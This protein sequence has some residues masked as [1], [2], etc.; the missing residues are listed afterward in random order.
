MRE[1]SDE[2]IN[3]VIWWRVQS[4]MIRVYGSSD[5]WDR[6]F[7]AQNPEAQIIQRYYVIY[8]LHCRIDATMERRCANCG[9]GCVSYH[10]DSTVDLKCIYGPR[11]FIWIYDAEH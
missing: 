9:R 7:L 10:L 2:I 5:F 6:A 4:S 11:C 8:R 1:G 3:A